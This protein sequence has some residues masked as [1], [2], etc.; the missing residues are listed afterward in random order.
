MYFH[1]V[2][3]GDSRRYGVAGRNNLHS[4]FTL[5]APIAA[6]KFNQLQAWAWA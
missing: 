1:V 6:L 5:Y 3:E 2:Y 4:S